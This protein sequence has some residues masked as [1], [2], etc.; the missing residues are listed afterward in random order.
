MPTVTQSWYKLVVKIVGKF[1]N[2]SLP[3]YSCLILDD[4]RENK[5]II[6]TDNCRILE[7]KLNLSQYKS[8]YQSL[9]HSMALKL[10]GPSHQM[11]FRCA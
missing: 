4:R 1:P 7:E 8:K 3:L 2:E 9:M 6:K 10:F 11:A 5:R